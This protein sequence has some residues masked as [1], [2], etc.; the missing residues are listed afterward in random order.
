MPESHSSGTA[1]SPNARLEKIPTFISRQPITGNVIRPT[2]CRQGN[3]SP[4]IPSI[5]PLDSQPLI[6]QIPTLQTRS[7][8]IITTR[9]LDLTRCGQELSSLATTTSKRLT[10]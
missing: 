7:T 10:A 2:C 1:A 9:K 5:T 3:Q 8:F 6:Q 4:S